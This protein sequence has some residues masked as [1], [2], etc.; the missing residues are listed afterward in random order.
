MGFVSKLKSILGQSNSPDGHAREIVAAVE[1]GDSATIRRLLRACPNLVLYK[2]ET[3]KSLL[4]MTQQPGIAETLIVNGAPVN[5]QDKDGLTPLH[6]AAVSG[7]EAMV[8]QMIVAGADVTLTTLKGA[9][10]GDLARANGHEVVAKMLP[11]S[12]AK[13]VSAT[14]SAVRAGRN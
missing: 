11:Q 9:T 2:G 7:N 1:S 12:M 6:H 8:Q 14:E 10:A 3:G 5:A 13:A 4:H